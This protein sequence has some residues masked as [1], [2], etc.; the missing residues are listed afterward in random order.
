MSITLDASA[1]MSPGES[2]DEILIDFPPPTYVRRFVLGYT[3]KVGLPD[4]SFARA[5]LPASRAERGEESSSDDN[6]PEV[7]AET[8]PEVTIHASVNGGV[9][10]FTNTLD[11]VNPNG[12]KG[13]ILV[14]T[15]PSFFFSFLYITAG[16]TQ[17]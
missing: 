15:F 8:G 5:W 6:K 7:Q 2:D 13:K 3:F 16:N 12:T 1:L 9:R 11:V 10:Y 14:C 17:E 4:F